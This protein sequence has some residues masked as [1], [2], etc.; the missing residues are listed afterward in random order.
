M[1]FVCFRMDKGIYKALVLVLL[2]VELF[3]IVSV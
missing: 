2:I 3:T 1:L